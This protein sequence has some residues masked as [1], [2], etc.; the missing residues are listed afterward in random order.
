MLLQE[1]QRAGLEIESSCFF[2]HLIVFYGKYFKPYK[3]L[4][5]F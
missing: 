2:N 4:P 3:K 5:K 1:I